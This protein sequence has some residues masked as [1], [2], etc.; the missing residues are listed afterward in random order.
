MFTRTCGLL[1]LCLCFAKVNLGADQQ[2]PPRA[3]PIPHGT[4]QKDATTQPLP[5]R[6]NEILCSYKF[7]ELS[8]SAAAEFEAAADLATPRSPQNCPPP[9]VMVYKNAEKALLKLRES[10]RATIQDSGP[11]AATIDKPT[12][13]LLSGGEFPILIP[14]GSSN[15][16]TIEWKK[17]GYRAEVVP[18]WLDTGRLHLQVTPEIVTKDIKQSVVAS[19]LTIPGLTTRRACMRV[20]MNLGETAVVNFGSDPENE[21][22]ANNIPHAVTLFM[23]TPVAANSSS[24]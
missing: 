11:I 23:V 19:G 1:V 14:T 7:V 15:R 2:S 5:A 3:E 8:A 10:G 22:E 16:V 20:E 21:D 9:V 24:K 18:H 13:T 12:T 4:Q 6:P 17:F